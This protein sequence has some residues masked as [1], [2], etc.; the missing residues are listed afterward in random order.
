MSPC[1]I[2][3]LNTKVGPLDAELHCSDLSCAVVCG[4][5]YILYVNY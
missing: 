5:T 4:F 2:H 3:P 1:K